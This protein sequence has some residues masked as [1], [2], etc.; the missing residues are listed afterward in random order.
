MTFAISI[1]DIFHIPSKETRDSVQQQ[2]Q[3]LKQLLLLLL[4]LLL[5][6]LATLLLW[7]FPLSRSISGNKCLFY[8]VLSD[9]SPSFCELR[10]ETEARKWR[11]KYL[12]NTTSCLAFLLGHSLMLCSLPQPWS[13]LIQTLTLLPLRR[14]LPRVEPSDLDGSIC[15]S[16]RLCFLLKGPWDIP[17]TH[18]VDRLW[19]GSRHQEWAGRGWAYP[20]Y[21]HG[22]SVN[23]R[24][25]EQKG[26]SWP[27]SF[28]AVWSLSAPA[29]LSGEPSSHGHRQLQCSPSSLIQPKSTCFPILPPFMEESSYIN[30]QHYL[31]E[32]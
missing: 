13:R 25:F 30:Y 31:S 3:L 7:W 28:L 2:N 1:S 18:P 11:Q 6:Y 22:L 4:F 8:T 5:F 9:H 29:C 32:T 19:A 14:R 20:L 21:K 17:E 16:P 10:L 12:T 26:L 15:S 23:F 24:G 27:H